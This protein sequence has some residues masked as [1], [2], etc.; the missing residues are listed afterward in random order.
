MRGKIKSTRKEVS[1]LHGANATFV[2][3]VDAGANETPFTIVKSKDGASAMS[4][5]KRG[6]TTAK[7][8]HKRTV[9][10][11]GKSAKAV[12][13]VEETRVASMVFASAQFET[14]ADVQ[15]YIDDAEWDASEITIAK[16]DDG[17]WEARADGLTDDDFDKIAEVNLD[18]EGV[19]AFVGKR[20]VE[21]DAEDASEEDDDDDGEEENLDKS[22]D[23][24]DE[25]EEDDAEED[26]DD[27]E[28][29]DEPVAKSAPKAKAKA[30][31]AANPQVKLSKR[32]QFLKKRSEERVTEKKFDQWGAYF[33]KGNTIGKALKDGMAWDG[34]PPG[35][36]DVQA[37]FNSAVANIVSDEDMGA[38]KQDALNKAASEY[39][40]IIGGLDTF[41]DAYVESDT[42]TVAKSFEDD[43]AR[44]A[45]SKWAEGFGDFVAGETEE[46]KAVAKSAVVNN[47]GFDDDKVTQLFKEALEPVAASVAAVTEQVEAIATRSPTKK[48]VDA[49]DG[50]A[51]SPRALK[52]REKLDKEADE[53]AKQFAKSTF[54]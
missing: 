8:S 11:K 27:A 38:G 39:A 25:D 15:A 40:E 44:E 14:E 19:S 33:S 37:A 26:E 35:Y 21:V 32:A 29:E 41:F 3:L 16:N 20:S 47:T 43:D 52:K 7:K 28:D 46:P 18:E 54:G 9:S 5:K 4:I 13:T 2:S 51:A 34:V 30:K 1:K 24:A 36:Y 12:E 48:A 45:L 10:P 6:K 31:K 53:R 42:E 49:E 22:E 17:D 23:D 50:T